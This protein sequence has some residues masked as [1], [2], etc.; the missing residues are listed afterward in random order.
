MLDARYTTDT[1][2]RFS[3]NRP[4]RINNVSQFVGSVRARWRSPEVRRTGGHPP[5]PRPS[6]AYVHSERRHRLSA[7]PRLFAK[8]SGGAA[9][10]GRGE[11]GGR[12][13]AFE[14]E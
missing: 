11:S 8:E 4:P 2:A 10:R 1:W 12:N 13:P 9:G 3:E 14:D 7:E 6:G 5:D